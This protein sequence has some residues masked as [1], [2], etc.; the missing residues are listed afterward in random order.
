MEAL[1][2][3]LRYAARQMLRQPVFATVAVVTLAIG[4]GANTAIFSVVNAVLIAPLPLG[5]P[6]R[7]VWLGARAESGFDISVSLPNY[8]DWE[9]RNTTFDAIG[10]A[11]LVSLNLTGDPP[12]RLPG[13]QVVGDYF[14]ALGRTPARGR[15]ILAEE[16]ARGADRPNLLD[17]ARS[18]R[19]TRAYRGWPESAGLTAT[20]RWHRYPAACPTRW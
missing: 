19:Y 13:R 18:T 16:T 15:P 1:L 6:D 17:R 4:I 10:A 8:Y 20:T 11:R 9:A 3:D 12:E 14:A 5:D 7:L 2:H